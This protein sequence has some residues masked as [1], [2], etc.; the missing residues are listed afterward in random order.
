MLGYESLARPEG[1]AAID[2][3]EAVFEAARSGGHKFDLDH[4]CRCKAVA[5]AEALPPEVTLFLN[6]SA[7]TSTNPVHG[8]DDLLDL[9]R[10]SKR[11]PQTVV[12]DITEHPLIRDYEV[13]HRVLAAYRARGSALRSTTSAKGTG[14]LSSLRHPRANTSSLDGA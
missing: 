2:S 1:F 13:L 3:V 7:S 5:D 9:L 10:T 12:L 6:I 4:I 8:V 11:A 14:H